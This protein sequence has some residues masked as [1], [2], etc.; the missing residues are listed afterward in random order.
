MLVRPI[1]LTTREPRETK[2]LAA[3][4]V[5]VEFQ[6][7]ENPL[8]QSEILRQFEAL[9]PE[10]LGALLTLLASQFNHPEPVRPN[11][12]EKNQKIEESVT[13]L[14]NQHDGH[15]KGT[16]TELIQ[17]TGL[18]IST[19]A[20]GQFLWHEEHENYHADLTRFRTRRLIALT[21]CAGTPKPHQSVQ[22]HW[23]YA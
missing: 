16:V 1:L 9:H 6:P 20:L 2:H 21:N 7:L 3:R 14:L 17:A 4:L 12:K 5:D 13:C 19:K 22:S 23:N 15:W 10:L 8:S 18:K 11:R